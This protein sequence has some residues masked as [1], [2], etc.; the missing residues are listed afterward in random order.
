MT[1]ISNLKYQS[2][3]FFI[4]QLCACWMMSNT[5]ALPNDRR[6]KL[7]ITADTTIY[8]YKSGVNYFE[9]HVLVDQGTT[10][11]TA[12]RLITKSDAAH[13]IIEAV[14]YGISDLAHFNTV[15]TNGEAIIHAKAKIIKF[16]PITMNTTLQGDVE[17]LQGQNNFHG[18]LIHYNMNDQT[19][20][21]PETKSGRAVLVYNPE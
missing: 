20:I 5:Y 3:I 9:G 10:H 17:V 15:P 16:Y 2:G 19:I 4:L 7:H 13:R 11:V 1:L 14:A 21:V 18:Q 6:A 8:N 12:D